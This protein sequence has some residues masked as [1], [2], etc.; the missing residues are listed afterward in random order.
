MKKI[1]ENIRKFLKIYVITFL[2]S[3]LIG[4]G[5]FLTFYFVEGQTMTGSIN[6]TGVAFISLLGIGIL[7]WIGHLGAFDTMS[8]GFKQMF[9]SMFN[10][11]A[12]KYND[13][14]A[15]KDDKN[16]K[17]KVSSKYYF[18]MMFVSI[19]FLIA[20]IALEIAKSSI[21]NV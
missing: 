4:L 16:S 11:E 19:I 8:Y 5:I 21:Y 18:V 1:I 7:L 10:K 12:N 17:R 3:S 13:F 20:F 15:Y 6:G 9:T 2:I 14:V